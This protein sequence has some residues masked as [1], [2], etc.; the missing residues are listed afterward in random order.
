MGFLRFLDSRE[1]FLFLSCTLLFLFDCTSYSRDPGVFSPSWLHP[2]SLVLSFRFVRVRRCYRLLVL[3]LRRKPHVSCRW[4]LVARRRWSHRV[5]FY[6]DR[7]TDICWSR[8]LCSTALV[9]VLFPV[10]LE[11]FCFAF[12]CFFFPPSSFDSVLFSPGFISLSAS[13]RCVCDCCP[14]C[15]SSRRR[16]RV[17]MVI[18]K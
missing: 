17:V 8:G 4:S 2:S 15:V 14:Y 5:V 13:I 18:R 12:V 10:C 16:P 11:V 1:M 6:C 7:T 9:C 3:F